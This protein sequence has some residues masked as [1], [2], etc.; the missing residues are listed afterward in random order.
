M[1]QPLAYPEILA[2]LVAHVRA[3]NDQLTDFN[4]GSV[5]RSWLEAAAIGL[6][7]LWL[8]TTQAITD[9]IPQA[10]FY[11]FDF[12]K[13]PA[14]YA[15]STVTFYVVVPPATDLEIPAGTRVRVLG[16]NAEYLT[17][18][19]ATLAAGTFEVTVQARAAQ[20][21]PDANAD[22]NS[23]SVLVTRTPAME[24]AGV[25]VTNRQP[26]SNGRFEETDAEQ[27]ARFA[28]YIAS[29]ARGTC[30]ALEYAARMAMIE[31]GGVIV[32]QVRHVVV[33]ETPGHVMLYVHNG[34]GATSPALVARAQALIEGYRDNAQDLTIFGYRPAGMAVECHALADVPLTVTADIRL[35]AGYHLAAVQEQA[36]AAIVSLLRY[37]TGPV[38]TVP[39]VIN[40]LYGISGVVNVVLLNPLVSQVYQR[41]E[42][43]VYGSLTLTEI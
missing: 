16:G 28:T 17:L 40:T 41:H 32:E 6:D 43:P 11:G 18:A 21:G 3:S 4:V 10:I 5:T 31:E 12:S 37:F 36:Q 14:T 2:R 42:R 8:W 34:I 9:A 7:E 27:R 39:E 30:G 19:S 23:L 1:F 33:H 26:I 38:L 25:A 13:Q 29:L 20:A 24:T 35:A 15:L 22:V